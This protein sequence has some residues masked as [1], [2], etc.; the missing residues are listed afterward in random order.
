VLEEVKKRWPQT[1][2]IIV[3]GFGTVETAVRAMR[4]GAFDVIIKPFDL[5]PFIRTVLKA[6][7]KRRGAAA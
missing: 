6:L 2:V 5:E 7:D 3:T 1:E 4:L